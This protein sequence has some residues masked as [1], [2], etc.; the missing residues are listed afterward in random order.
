[1]E[2]LV[3]KAD[4]KLEQMLEFNRMGVV[5]WWLNGR[6]LRRR[7]FGLWQIKILNLLT[8]LFRVFDK[9]L[10]LPPLSLIAIMRKPMNKELPR[11]FSVALSSPHPASVTSLQ[12]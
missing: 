5:A 3:V 7:T 2:E 9:I 10:P 1:L 12:E 6:V 4:L 8:P 11:D